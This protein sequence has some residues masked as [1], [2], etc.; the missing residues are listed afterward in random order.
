MDRFRDFEQQRA[1]RV[2][3]GADRLDS[4]DIDGTRHLDARQFIDRAKGS[5]LN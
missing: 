4:L 2:D 1:N 5:R 3:G